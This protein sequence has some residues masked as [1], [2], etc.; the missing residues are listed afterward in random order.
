MFK[1]GYSVVGRLG[2]KVRLILTCKHIE[3]L[4]FTALQCFFVSGGPCG[5]LVH[6]LS[7][8]LFSRPQQQPGV[9]HLL[10]PSLCVMLAMMG[11]SSTA[12]GPVPTM[13]SATPQAGPAAVTENP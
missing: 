11:A 2:A 1:G 3:H 12:Q 4:T 6:A 5:P 13:P 10:D 7:A 9:G 8:R